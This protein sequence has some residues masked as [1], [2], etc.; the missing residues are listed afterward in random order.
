MLYG[1]IIKGVG[2]LYEVDVKDAVYTCRA[3][4]V[5]RNK[6]I[7]PVIGDMC[8]VQVVSEKDKTATIVEIMQRKNEIVR[9]RVSN[10]DQIIIVMAANEP[11][12]DRNLLDRYLVILENRNFEIVICINKADLSKDGETD[13]IK[14]LYEDIGYKVIFMSVASPDRYAAFRDTLKGKVSAFAG[15]SG[16]GKSSIVNMLVGAEMMQTG[17]I[18]KK[19]S[20]GKHT[21]RHVE[22]I[23][24]DEDTYVMDTP[25]F[26]SLSF[27]GIELSDLEYLFVEFQPF[28][29]KCAFRNCAHISEP[30]CA[31][32]ERV[33]GI[34]SIERY[35]NYLNF[36]DEIKANRPPARTVRQATK[37]GGQID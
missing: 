12:I 14:T 33:D 22:F 24:L 8:A 30:G 15:P 26:T 20:R 3:V 37:E 4:G 19:I 18:S 1:R 9:P 17:G 10:I 2:G 29:N 16:V 23:G 7:T 5:F 13:E 31:V 6:R 27:D 34:I 25:G 35:N 11:R 32:K 36:Y 21:T 28:L